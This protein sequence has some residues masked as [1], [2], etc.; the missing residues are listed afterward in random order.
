MYTA[1]HKM[2][3]MPRPNPNRGFHALKLIASLLI[4]TG[5]KH[6]EHSPQAKEDDQIVG[7]RR[8]HVVH[9][10]RLWLVARLRQSA[11]CAGGLAYG[12]AY[13]RQARANSNTFM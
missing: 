3:R 8:P 11:G 5:K 9:R 7:D 2:E 1:G 13:A 10:K 12:M 4:A 6:E